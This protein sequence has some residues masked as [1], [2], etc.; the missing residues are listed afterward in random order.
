MI[1]KCSILLL[2]TE[3]DLFNGMSSVGARARIT[4]GATHSG[5]SLAK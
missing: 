4:T 3:P 5:P 1:Y 2:Y